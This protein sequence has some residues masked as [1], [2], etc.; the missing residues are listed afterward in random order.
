M[1]WW[2]LYHIDRRLAEKSGRP[3]FIRDIEINVDDFSEDKTSEMSYPDS[4]VRSYLQ[5]VIAW[6]RLWSQTWDTFFA[7]KAPKLGDQS[8][9]EAMDRQIQDLRSQL[10][11]LLT[12]DSASFESY[13]KAGEDQR[14]IRFR[15]LSNTVN[16]SPRTSYEELS[17]ER[18]YSSASI[19]CG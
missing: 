4:H 9:I 12:W 3:Y 18:R 1:L 15:L 10:P 13:T 19:F 8:A 7:L 11:S 2:S 5:C 16:R 17:T 6:G 14:M